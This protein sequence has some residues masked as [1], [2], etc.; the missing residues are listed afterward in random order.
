VSSERLRLR[1]AHTDQ[2]A[3]GLLAELTR[4]CEAA[5]EESFEG[6]WERVGSGVHVM[7]EVDGRVVAHAMIIDRP[8]YVGDEMDVAL[9]VG[10]VEHVATLPDEQGRG[11]GAAVMREVNGIIGDEY[12]LG[13]LATGS[14]GFYARLGWETWRARP[15]PRGGRARNGAPDGP[16]PTPPGTRR[17]HRRRLACRGCVVRPAPEGWSGHGG[18]IGSP[19]EP[20]CASLASR[21]QRRARRRG[22]ARIPPRQA[23]RAAVG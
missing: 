18:C 20:Q 12:A 2:L 10:Y 5:F 16:H 6:V 17:A 14:N 3:P 19:G 13:A 9:D 21:R 8:L 15:Q 23:R 1:T 11:H 7:A 4:L 22:R